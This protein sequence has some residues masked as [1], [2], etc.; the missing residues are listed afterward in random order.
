MVF[1]VLKILGE[2]ENVKTENIILKVQYKSS[3][4]NFSK[5]LDIIELW[6][7]F[8]S[9]KLTISIDGDPERNKY[10]RHGADSWLLKENLAIVRKELGNKVE[11][12]ATLQSQALNTLFG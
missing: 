2:Q 3:K 7:K 4:L 1:K 11:V 5:K 6:K 12:K 10:I 8:K 9:I